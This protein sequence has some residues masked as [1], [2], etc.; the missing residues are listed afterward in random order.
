MRLKGMVNVR[1]ETFLMGSADFYVEE[2]PVTVAEVGDLWVDEHPVTNAAFRRFV[3]DTGHVTVAER[4]PDPA[5]FPE[6]D[7]A[8]LVAGSMVFLPPARP[9][10]LDDWT[11]WW[12][13][14]PG[15][16]WRHPDGPASTLHGKELH[17][18]VHVGFEDACA[19]ALWAGV[20]LPTEAEWEH[21]ARGGLDGATY[22]WGEEFMPRGHVMANT[23][24]G[25]FPTENLAPHG[26]TRTSPVGKFA[27][28]GFGLFDVTGNVWEWTSSAWKD[29][30]APSAGVSGETVA[31]VCC[32]PPGRVGERDRFVM[33]GGSHLCAPSYCHRYRPAARQAHGSRDTTSH[34]GFRCVRDA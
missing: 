11:Q 3:R 17:P 27:P 13:W 34:L 33:K 2:R 32:G 10:S 8:Q 26:Y 19:Y 5:D 30:H 15:A 12:G 20:R 16:D 18:V 21:A 28:N 25:R 22:A 14:V 31:A 9:V 1:G 23:W 6:A 24:H 29:D 4:A 7:R